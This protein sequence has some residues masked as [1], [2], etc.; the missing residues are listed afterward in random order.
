MFAS[1]ANNDHLHKILRKLGITRETSYP[2]EWFGAFL[3]DITFVVLHLDD[4]RRL[5]GWPL[6]WPSQPTTGHFVIAEPSW[7][8]DDGTETEVTGV[9]KIVVRANDVKWVE[10]LEKNWE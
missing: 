1:F 6:E 2:S 10:F 4:E 3:N 7:L 9:S 8:N 5:Y